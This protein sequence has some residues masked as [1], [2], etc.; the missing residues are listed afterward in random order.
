MS[1]NSE[2]SSS[3]QMFY[4]AEQA[5]LKLAIKGR[6][7]AVALITIL[8]A[9]TRGADRA[10]EFILAGLAFVVLGLIHFRIIGTSRDRPWVKYVFVTIDLLLLS[11]AVAF[12]PAEPGLQ[13]P[14]IIIFRFQIFPFYFLILAVAAFSFWPVL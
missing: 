9:V 3:D 1:S 11:A 7:V 4:E 10:P 12:L 14:D 8:M 6:I 2:I 5:G 13:L